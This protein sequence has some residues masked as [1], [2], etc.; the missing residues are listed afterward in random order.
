M[1]KSR[2]T[3]PDGTVVEIGK[4]TTPEQIQA[5]LSILASG[6]T[7]RP[8]QPTPVTEATLSA[9]EIWEY[10]SKKE[11]IAHFVRNHFSTKEWFTTIDVR[12]QQLEF[13]KKM[14]FGESSAIATY[15]NRLTDEGL[16]RKTKRRKISYQITDKLILEYPSL[17]LHQITELLRSNL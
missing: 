15:L 17:E 11:R 1:A 2:V 14:V 3:F 10:G 16:L 12:D 6:Q 7:A 13:V 9:D 8:M 5:I 4:D